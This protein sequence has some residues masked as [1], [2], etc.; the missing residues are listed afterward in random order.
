M[1]IARTNSDAPKHQ[2]ISYFAIDMH[3]HGVD[4]RP[5]RELTGRALF[6]EVFMT[7]ARVPDD[8]VIGDRNNGWA[9]ANSTLVH[10]RAGLGSGGGSSSSEC[11]DPRHGRRSPRHSCRRL[12]QRSEEALDGR[13]R[14]PVPGHVE[15]ADQPRQGAG[16]ANDPTIR[17]DLMRLYTIASSAGS[18]TCG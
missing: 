4:I 16:V 9:V 11:R 8:A 12:R 1:L 17:Q 7:D 10:E 5:L 2:G 3:Q 6:N 13:R 14:C 15:D 18:T